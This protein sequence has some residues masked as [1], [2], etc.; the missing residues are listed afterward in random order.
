MT[1]PHAKRFHRLVNM[2]P[3]EIRAWSKDPRSTIASWAST[4]SRLPALAK[5][6][7][8]PV[9]KWTEKD[10]VFAK[11]VVSFNARMD[12]AR[13]VHGCTPKIDAALRNWGRR[14]P[15]CSFSSKRR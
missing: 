3:A 4:R 1:C 12:G 15:G 7:A 13:K 14:A 10:C 2:T 11:R 9:A 5:L 8:K 6:K